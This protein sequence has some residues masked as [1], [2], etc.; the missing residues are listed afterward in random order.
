MLGRVTY[1]QD[2]LIADPGQDLSRNV[3]EAETLMLN[4]HQHPMVLWKPVAWL[5]AAL[6]L[7]G[8]F[9][10][11]NSL[12]LLVLAA[13]FAALANLA[14]RILER[15]LNSFAATDR[16]VLRVDGVINKSFPMMRL[17]KI[18]DMRLD[19]P[20]LGRLLGYGTL[21]IESAGQDQ[22]LREL[23]YTPH[24]TQAYRRL[25]ATIFGQE[26]LGEDEPI[27]PAPASRAASAA[28]RGARR[29][30]TATRSAGARALDRRTDG[31]PYQAQPYQPQNQTSSQTDSPIRTG[32]GQGLFGSRD[33]FGV[34]DKP[35]TGGS[36]R[37][38]LSRRARRQ[39]STAGSPP[40]AARPA[41][42]AT[43]PGTSS[44]ERAGLPHGSH[45]SSRGDDTDELPT[46][47][48][49]H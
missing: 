3:T 30:F 2:P 15:S 12:P 11:D 49:P 10:A 8:T 23:R 36:R 22:T 34:G 18:T 7:L 5:L 33:P 21:T 27:R 1:G 9:L 25:N 46:V 42:T 16:R 20:L 13:V 32:Q 47:K 4:L 40:S 6:L 24:P 31:N 17:T 26:F 41:T 35:K 29:V 37:G 43:P 14:W 38:R 45:R 44:T 48:R 19:Q 39:A 28:G